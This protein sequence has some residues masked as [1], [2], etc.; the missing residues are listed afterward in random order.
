MLFIG[1]IIG[2]LNGIKIVKL[3]LKN[4]SHH[5]IGE[6]NADAPKFRQ[7][8]LCAQKSA[9]LVP[10]DEDAIEIRSIHHGDKPFL[11]LPVSFLPVDSLYPHEEIIESEYEHVVE[12]LKRDKHLRTP[13]LVT[14]DNVILDG[15]HRYA[16]FKKLHLSEIPAIVL[17][18]DDD[19]LIT[20]G[21]WYPICDVA[22][23]TFKHQIESHGYELEEFPVD[24]IDREWLEQREYN[25][26]F[27]NQ[28]ERYAT[29][30]DPTVVFQIIRNHYLQDIKY[31]DEPN[32]AFK[33]AEITHTAVISWSYT[34]AEVVKMAK[35]AE[36]FLP[37]TTRHML[38]YQFPDFNIQLDELL[39][40]D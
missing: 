1:I 34:K 36:V 2:A 40:R 38:K 30:A 3:Y 15:H 8:F 13:I 7:C 12:S 14:Q 33:I 6:S 16:A 37:K 39:A 11:D 5:D 25:I 19:E 17:N 26:I 21:R 23:S 31:S 24:T 20:V 4:P 22:V 29:S 28:K 18:Y 35:S 27:G 9:G 32:L 10:K